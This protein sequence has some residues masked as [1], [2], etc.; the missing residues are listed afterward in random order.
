M[1]L[2]T[3]EVGLSAEDEPVLEYALGDRD[4]ARA[5][6]RRD[7]LLT[8]LPASALAGRMRERAEAMLTLK[9]GALDAKPPTAVDAEW[10]ARRPDAKRLRQAN[11]AARLPG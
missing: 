9:N 10:D 8:S 4:G 7:E 1:L 2:E 3:F 5:R 6:G 11:R